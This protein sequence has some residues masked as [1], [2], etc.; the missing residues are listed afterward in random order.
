MR[1]V[2]SC[3]GDGRCIGMRSP[4]HEDTSTSLHG[5]INTI[6]FRGCNGHRPKFYD[7]RGIA[8]AAMIC[9]RRGCGASRPSRSRSRPARRNPG[10][11][12]LGTAIAA[13]DRRCGRPA[14]RGC[15]QNH[16][17][18][19]DC[20]CDYDGRAGPGRGGGHGRGNKA[21]PRRARRQVGIGGGGW[22]GGSA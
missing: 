2:S 11:R 10:R 17:G 19:P 3:N 12:R 6:V 9:D 18:A 16:G 13:A 1:L 4:I 21:R 20:A 15:H 22:G 5:D 14:P 7:W 8:T